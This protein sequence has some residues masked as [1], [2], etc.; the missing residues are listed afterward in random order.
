MYVPYRCEKKVQ[1]SVLS[2]WLVF[3]E[4]TYIWT[5][6]SYDYNV[7]VSALSIVLTYGWRLCFV[8]F[9]AILWCLRPKPNGK[10]YGITIIGNNS[11][12]IFELYEFLDTRN[13]L[14]RWSLCFRIF[15]CKHSIGR[16]LICLRY[17]L[18]TSA[19]QFYVNCFWTLCLAYLLNRTTVERSLSKNCPAIK[20]KGI[21]NVRSRISFRTHQ[22]NE[23]EME[24]DWNNI[25]DDSNT[26]RLWMCPLF[27]YP[28][29]FEYFM[30]L[31]KQNLMPI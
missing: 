29:S 25:H 28:L 16:R 7:K 9:E 13:L 18:A 21:N 2:R 5:S 11:E 24:N 14:G 15:F 8:L 3:L 23:W 17:C 22:P 30:D 27:V 4:Q 10:F 26:F 19:I 20:I 6:I 31:L 1:Y 12:W